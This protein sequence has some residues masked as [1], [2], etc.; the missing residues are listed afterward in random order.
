MATTLEINEHAV[1]TE[2]VTYHDPW[3]SQDKFLHFSVSAAITGISYRMNAR[4]FDMELNTAKT[5]SVSFTTLIGIG[6]ELFDKK[7]KGHF[8]WKDLLW[9]GAGIMVGY[10]VFCN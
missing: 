5:V 2:P 4:T 1:F 8:S 9:D 7:T 6:K 3:L 10:L